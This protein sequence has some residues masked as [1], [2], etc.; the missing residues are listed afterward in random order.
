MQKE[1]WREIVQ[2]APFGYAYHRLLTGPTGEPEDYVFLEV[3][4]AFEQMTGLRAEAVLGQ[5]ATVVLP[6]IRQGDFDWVAVY[7][8]VALTGQRQQFTQHSR[9][10]Q[11]TYK[12]TAL[13]PQPGHFVTLFQDVTEETWQIEELEGRQRLIL[14]LTRELNLIFNGTSDAMF[15]M[16]VEADGQYRCLRVNESYRRL[17]GYSSLELIGKTPVEV[18]GRELGEA[19]EEGY[20]RCVDAKARVSYEETLDFPS[21]RRNWST[22]LTPIM[23]G[24]QVRFLIGSRKDIT[25]QRQAEA[26]REDLSRRLQSMFAAHTAVLL[27]IEPHSGRIVD[28]NPSACAF[29]GYPREE[30]LALRIQDINVLPPDEVERLRLAALSQGRRYFLFPHRLKNGEIRWVDVYSSPV[31]DAAGPLLFSIIFDATERE[32]YRTSL[33]QEKELLRTTL[34]SIGDGVV[35]TDASGRIRSVNKAAEEISGWSEAAAA[36]RPFGEV[37]RLVSEA[38]GSPSPDPVGKVLQT[39]LTLGLANHTSLLTNDGRLVSLADS[40]APIRDDR[41]QL[42]GVVMVFRD[43]TADREQQERILYLSYYDQLT[44]LCNRRFMEE[45]L[46]RLDTPGMLPLAV[47]MGDLNGLKLTNDI[48]GHEAGDSLLQRAA[49]AILACC[50]PGDVAIRWGGDEFVILSPQTNEQQVEQVLL[51][52]KSKC[53]EQAENQLQLSLAMGYALK[54]SSGEDL[55][56]TVKEAEEMM[57]RQKLLEGKSYRNAIINTLQATMLAKS[58]ETEAHAARLRQHCLRIGRSFGLPDKALDELALLAVLHDIGKVGVRESVLQKPGPLT[59]AE[60]AEIRR[61]PEIGYRIAQNTP[62]LAAV[63]EYI[64]AHH[65]RWDGKGYPRGLAG[66]EIPLLARILSVVDAFDAMVSERVY[67]P[68]LPRQQALDEIRSNAGQQFDPEVVTA[69][70]AE[71]DR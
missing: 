19:V 34:Y 41:G 7:G 51:N 62:E 38:D 45:A 56:Q 14:E 70:L 40:A 22:T 53:T 21:G 17:V 33:Q 64:L 42:L 54:S 28:A 50:R 13:S 36:G 24:D 32:Q 4:P 59:E 46:P 23:E 12:V 65:E 57:Y 66:A 25:A 49:T 61:H 67:R 39:G 30:L 26:E 11:R 43:V 2:Q 37:F 58:F 71:C 3:N 60:W 69:F 27:M 68:A 1:L 6:G 55:W 8:R 5:R 29:Y 16:Q 35:T 52:I 47:I 15:L 31:D 48:F 18:M 9:P 20:R 44:G 63:S 10:L